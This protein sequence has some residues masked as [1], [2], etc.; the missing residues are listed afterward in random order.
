MNYAGYEIRHIMHM[1]RHKSEASVRRYNRD[2]STI[3]KKKINMSDTL[4]RLAVSTRIS[5]SEVQDQGP[6][7]DH[8]LWC[9]YFCFIIQSWSSFLSILKHFFQQDLWQ[10][11]PSIA[12]F[13]ILKNNSHSHT[14]LMNI[15]DVFHPHQL[16][17]DRC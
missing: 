7:A 16:L 2:C 1:S 5:G 3:Q 14:L 6:S 11:P 13:L 12:A 4:N 10:T 15:Q 8:I 17:V 9:S